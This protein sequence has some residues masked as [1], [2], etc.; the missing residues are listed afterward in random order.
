MKF[1]KQWHIVY[2]RAKSEKKMSELL[3][4]KNIESFYLLNKIIKHHGVRQ[5]VVLEPLISRFLFVRISKPEIDIVKQTEGFFNFIYWLNEEVI[6]RNEEINTLQQFANGQRNIVI[7]KIGIDINEH[8]KVVH[9]SFMNKDN[10]IDISR[11]I[12]KISVP[13]I[14]YSLSAD[15][16]TA[17]VQVIDLAGINQV[18]SNAQS[19]A[20]R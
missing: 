16:Q 3:K 9:S 19:A 18:F 4:K 13:L 12:I 15:V 11:N 10:V 14:G 1:E 20:A 17:K 2:T 6:I 5:K 8:V 7:E